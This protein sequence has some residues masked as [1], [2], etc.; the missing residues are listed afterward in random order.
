[1]IHV[2]V[3]QGW[4]SRKSRP[5]IIP[6]I[7][8][9]IF[10]IFEAGIFR[11]FGIFRIYDIFDILGVKFQVKC[12]QRWSQ[13]DEKWPSYRKFGVKMTEVHCTE[14]VLSELT[15]LRLPTFEWVK[16]K[17]V[18]LALFVY[19]CNWWAEKMYSPSTEYIPCHGPL[20]KSIY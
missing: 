12:T 20:S 19:E 14:M 8:P 6:K 7:P 13:S 4:Q 15:W 5:G 16:Y 1:M 17:H 3:L 2:C 9:G 11:I 18:I 10:G